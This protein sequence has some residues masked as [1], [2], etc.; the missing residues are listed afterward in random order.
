MPKKLTIALSLS[1]TGRYSAMGRQ[2]EAAIRLFADDANA[3]GGI[4][5]SGERYEIGLECIDDQSRPARA[6]EIYRALCIGD[7]R[8]I[9]GPYSSELTRTAAPIAEAAGMLLINH[10]GA[11]DQIHERGY[12]MIAG[13]LT[14]ASEYMTGF[15]HLLTTLKFWRKRVAIVCSNG[16]F[17]RAVAAGAERA[18]DERL[19]RRRGVRVR[20]KYAGAFEP[21][22]T[23]ELL[24]R[25]MRRNRI[26]AMISAGGYEHELAMVRMAIGPRFNIPVLACVAAGVDAF[27]ADLGEDAEGIV[28]VSQWEP[29]LDIQP[30][31]GP[32]AA[33]FL[34]RMRNA[35]P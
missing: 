21:D 8:M 18:C 19:A 32:G 5:A 24:G 31:I 22:E 27:G 11:D 16:P 12:R 7:P 23:P 10:G 34:R 6:A 3:S 1:L 20:L 26:N 25:A 30:E 17:G 4:S 15:V 2:A 9:L 29:S 28:G 33:E 13:V 35:F 14:P